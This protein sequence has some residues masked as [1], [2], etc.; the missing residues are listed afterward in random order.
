MN[1]SGL[2]AG[3]IGAI[4]PRILGTIQVST[5]NTTN[6]DFSRTPNYRTY[7]NV[8]MQVQ[9]LSNQDL[10]QM[11]GLNL[12]GNM[13]AIYITGPVDGVVRATS[14]GGDLITLPDSSIWLVTIV[15]EDWPDWT[16]VAVT[17]Q[18]S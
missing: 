3:A 9:A 4:N 16:K 11:E 14:K 17:Q 1:L 5:G 10:K 7:R 12:Q 15:L 18:N 13:K 8:P 6:A 2:V